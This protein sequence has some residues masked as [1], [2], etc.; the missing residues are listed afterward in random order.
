M[1]LAGEALVA[2]KAVGVA[3]VGG[4]REARLLL[5]VE[6]GSIVNPCL[7]RWPKNR[8]KALGI[9]GRTLGRGLGRPSGDGCGRRPRSHRHA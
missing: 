6:R 1:D 9:V 5:D 8:S 2:E 3:R 7:C 4:F